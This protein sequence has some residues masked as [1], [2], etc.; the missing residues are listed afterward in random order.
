MSAIGKGRA[1]SR[2]DLTADYLRL[3]LH[4]DPSTGIFTWV[5]ARS[6][7]VGNT[8]GSLNDKGYVVIKIDDRLYKAH[9]LAVLYMTGEWPEE[10]VD[11]KNRNKS[12]NRWEN[13]REATQAQNSANQC[14]HARNKNGAKGVSK[15]SNGK[16][17]VVIRVNYRLISVGTFETLVEAKT[18]HAKAHAAAFGE[19]SHT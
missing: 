17:R 4:Y 13:L 1:R 6:D 18:A 10:T 3:R 11:H 9:R 16:Y 19:F 8:A 7:N 12:D 5:K 14:M 15:C 2:L